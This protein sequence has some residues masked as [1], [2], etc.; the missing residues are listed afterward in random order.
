MERNLSKQRILEQYLNIAEFGRGVYGVNAAA[1]YYWGIPA[2]RLSVQQAI[3]LAA[4]LPAPV[5]HNPNSRTRFF[6]KRVR[7]ISR[8]F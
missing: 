3:E 4:T 8:Y 6:K 1:Q 7:K 5:N 2:S